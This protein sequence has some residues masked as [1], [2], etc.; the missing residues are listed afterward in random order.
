MKT[1]VKFVA[2]A[3]MLCIAGATAP[4]SAQT[5][6]VVTQTLRGN[7]FVG[8]STGTKEC[9]SVHWT[10]VRQYGPDVKSGPLSGVVF[11]D[12]GSGTSRMKGMS[13]P[14]E[15]FVLDLTSIEGKGPVGTVTGVRKADGELSADFVSSTGDCKYSMPVMEM[16]RTSRSAG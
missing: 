3:G 6:N 15:T 10:L 9:P 16:D 2:L 4:A 12:N 11:Y 7:T 13:K 5:P 8:Y 1:S 14:D